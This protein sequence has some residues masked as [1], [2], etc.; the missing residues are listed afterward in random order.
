M[1]S[2]KK[3]YKFFLENIQDFFLLVGFFLF[4]GGAYM[5]YPEL[6]LMLGG[7]LLL[8]AGFPRKKN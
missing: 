4:S 1:G 5:I 6:G 3:I 8:Y 2:M 7:A